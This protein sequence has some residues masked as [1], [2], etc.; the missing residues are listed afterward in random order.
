MD[1]WCAAVDAESSLAPGGWLHTAMEQHLGPGF[2]GEVADEEAWRLLCSRV[3]EYTRPAM[4]AAVAGGRV[5]AD[6]EEQARRLSSEM[7]GRMLVP[8]A[9]PA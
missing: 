1:A 3:W 8:A 7:L 6:A 5:S 9:H 2:S 4:I